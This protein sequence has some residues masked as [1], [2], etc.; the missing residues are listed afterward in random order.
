MTIFHSSIPRGRTRSGEPIELPTHQ[1]GR[2][3]GLA[4]ALKN[5]LDPNR[6]ATKLDE[7]QAL[8]GYLLP[9]RI[10]TARG[11]IL[12]LNT[13]LPPDDTHR[14]LIMGLIG[15]WIRNN[16]K[17]GEPILLGGDLNAAW[18]ITDRPTH[19]LTARDT[20]TRQWLTTLELKPTDLWLTL[21]PQEHSYE[22]HH[23]NVTEST[24]CS[25]VDDWLF[26][27]SNNLGIS[28]TVFPTRTQVISEIPH[29]SDRTTIQ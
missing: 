10:E 28:D 9:L 16:R 1:R 11:C 13:Y 20:R 6:I 8:R 17:Q 3:A 23:S 4:T 14:E 22:T 21:Q 7:T 25:R 5:S 24:H 15:S 19:K 27:S 12:V 29:T 26:P 2:R 18:M